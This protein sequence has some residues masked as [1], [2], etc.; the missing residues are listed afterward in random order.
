MAN[1]S[2][3]HQWAARG[4]QA[5]FF[6][7]MFMGGLDDKRAVQVWHR[8]AGKD[9]S[10]INF[11]AVA[12]Q[13]RV[14]TIWH[15]LPT[16]KQGRRAIWNAIDREGRRVVDQAF[17]RELVK[18]KNNSDMNLELQNGSMYQVVGSDNYDSLVG[19][20]PVGVIFS[21]Y[22]IADPTAWDYIR[23]ILAENNGWA[24]FIYTARGK[25]HGYRLAE[26]A[27]K[28]PK[29]FY[30]LKTVDDTKRGDGT[31][32]ITPEMIEEERRSG[33]SEEKVQQEYYCSFDGGMEGAFY[34]RE[35]NIA[36]KEGRIGDF[37]YDPR[38]PVQTWW[39][40]GYRDATSIVFTQRD[41]HNNP[42]I[43]DYWEERNRDLAYWAKE[44]NSE[45]YAYDERHYGPHDLNN[46]DWTTGKTKIEMAEMLGL[47]FEMVPKIPVDDGIEAT[48]A[49]L[50]VAKFNKT[51]VQPLL[52]RL[53][54]Y[55]RQYD[56]STRLFRDK[57]YHDWCSHGADAT[58]YMSVG[59][60][61]FNPH[62]IMDMQRFKVISAMGNR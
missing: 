23:P 9:S 17:P 22:S 54:S 61:E 18:S 51:K 8:R 49:M 45:R 43:I 28:N 16:L 19:S 14:G 52:D 20:N 58:R 50:Q 48:R 25:N 26:M 47:K 33:M 2:L 44:I 15:M 21:E 39:D 42:I 3:P 40:I 11:A 27:K 55:R 38:K 60:D 53:A 36:E 41:D 5:D 4:Y 31:P 1:I 34:T 32:V 29:W 30:S 24:I 6:Q 12:S 35:L 59:W 37:P 7:H 13:M 10:S 46:T 62:T 56:E 57:P